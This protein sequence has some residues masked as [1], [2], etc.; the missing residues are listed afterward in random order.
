MDPLDPQDLPFADDDPDPL[1]ISI[2]AP[3]PQQEFSAVLDFGD[4][5]TLTLHT[6]D[7]GPRPSGE[8]EFLKKNGSETG[9]ILQVEPSSTSPTEESDKTVWNETLSQKPYQELAEMNQHSLKDSNSK[10]SETDVSEVTDGK[11]WNERCGGV[12]GNPQKPSGN[13]VEDGTH[14]AEDTDIITIITTSSSEQTSG[15]EGEKEGG[16]VEVVGQGGGDV[17][18]EEENLAAFS[19]DSALLVSPWMRVNV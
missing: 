19:V 16:K 7:L 3:T 11:V 12:N 1:I 10:N 17:P 2:P 15:G 8:A 4:S 9:Q 14:P 6:E 18:S 5:K 13:C